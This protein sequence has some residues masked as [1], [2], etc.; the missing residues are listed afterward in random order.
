MGCWK[1]GSL[2]KCHVIL[3]GIIALWLQG[4]VAPVA[5]SV[6]SAQSPVSQVTIAEHL[7][8]ALSPERAEDRAVEAFYA[9]RGHVPLWLDD[10]QRLLALR[11]ALQAAPAHALPDRSAILPVEALTAADEL[12]ITRVYL[13]HARALSSGLLDPRR[14]SRDMTR[15]PVRPA[16]ADLLTGLAEAEDAAAF[17]AGLAPQDPGYA[18]LL[19]RYR[20]LS[21]LPADAWGPTVPSGPILRPGESSPRVRALRARLVALGELDAA[22]PAEPDRYDGRLAV[23]VEAFQRRHGLNDDAAVGPMTL[24]ALNASPS[25]RAAQIAVNLERMRWLNHPLGHRRIVVN[26]ADFTVTLYE[27]AE[28]LFH[29]R[30]IVGMVDRQT[31]EFSDTMTHLVFNP[32]WFVPRSIATRDILP[33]LRNDPTYLA[34][35]NM[36]LTR[37]DGGPLPADPSAHDFTAY[38]AGSFPYRIRQR[39]DPDNAL[40]Q[41]KFMF[42]NNHAVYLHDT[43][44]R[45]LF[46][47]DQRAFSS[48]CV[49]VR[50]PLRLAALLLAPQRDDPAASI[51]AMLASGRERH[52][53]LTDPVAVHLVYRTAWRDDAG[54]DQFRADVYGRDAAVV[55]AL[56]GAGVVLPGV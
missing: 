37:A 51:D 15:V 3:C 36:V 13:A 19:E 41:V 26:Q 18:A 54:R 56:R 48:G 39:P 55:Q 4:P 25:D 47:R 14:I 32:T 33:K 40:G 52:V 5:A 11:A 31:P 1:T 30:A 42:P 16:T 21:A 53:T 23:A 35:S 20:Q 28:V 17:L 38:S 10:H 49:R 50:D 24:A 9:A 45:A 22:T 12:A 34:R 7:A 44:N 29:E 6:P 46:A 43:P 8:S 27:G 2:Q